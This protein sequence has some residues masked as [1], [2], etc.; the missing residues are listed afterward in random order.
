MS[1][2]NAKLEVLGQISERAREI[3]ST[4]AAHPSEFSSA[5]LNLCLAQLRDADPSQ[6]REALLLVAATVVNWLLSLDRLDDLEPP[7]RCAS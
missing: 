2:N 5:A 3:E 7:A 1:N 4:V 6:L